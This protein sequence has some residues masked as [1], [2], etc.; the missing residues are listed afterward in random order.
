MARLFL[1]GWSQQWIS[2]VTDSSNLDQRCKNTCKP[3]F[4]QIFK[5]SHREHHWEEDYYIY[6]EQKQPKIFVIA[7]SYTRSQPR[8]V[9]IKFEHTPPAI[10]AMTTPKRLLQRN[11]RQWKYNCIDII[12]LVSI[13]RFNNI[14]IMQVFNGI[15]RNTQSKSYRRSL[16]ECVRNFQNDACGILINTPHYF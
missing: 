7:F 6:E 12:K 8:A 15:S 4:L 13:G 14:P 3:P 5:Y 2:L 16:T 10:L 1:T 9:M 11:G